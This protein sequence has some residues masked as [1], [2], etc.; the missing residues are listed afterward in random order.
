MNFQY[1]FIFL[2]RHEN[3]F[4]NQV[5]MLQLFRRVHFEDDVVNKD[6]KDNENLIETSK[7]ETNY[8]YIE[9]DETEDDITDVCET[10]DCDKGFDKH[11]SNDS[12]VMQLCSKQTGYDTICRNWLE[13]TTGFFNN[14]SEPKKK[15]FDEKN[16]FSE[17]DEIFNR[18]T[19]IENLS[20]T[21]EHDDSSNKSSE[22]PFFEVFEGLEVLEHKIEEIFDT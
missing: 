15:S 13:K 2:I 4:S 8:G 6:V 3:S 20:D 22:R 14:H 7:N 11:N 21:E 12:K 9:N 16:L 17:Q 19:K 10:E 5:L 1:Q 18:M